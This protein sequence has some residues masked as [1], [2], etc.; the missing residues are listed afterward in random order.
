ME[1]KQLNEMSLLEL[2]AIAYDMILSLEQTRNQLQMV[3]DRIAQLQQNN[4]AH[5][6][7]PEKGA[8]SIPG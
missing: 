3:T 1:T 5:V 4:Q 8:D 2:K 6:T 7:E